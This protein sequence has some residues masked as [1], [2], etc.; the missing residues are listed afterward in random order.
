LFW[1]KKREAKDAKEKLA[2]K[3]PISAAKTMPFGI[4]LDFTKAADVE[5]A[6]GGCEAGRPTSGGYVLAAGQGVRSCASIGVQPGD[7]LRVET[8]LS[9]DADPTNG[10]PLHY[11]VGV[12]VYDGLG[13]ILTWWIHKPPVARSAGIVTVRDDVTMPKG[14]VAARY[15][16]CGDWKGEGAVSNGRINLLSATVRRL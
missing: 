4:S 6:H 10:E 9:V 8:S 5:A 16:A 11:F 3:T 1:G 13:E 2:A 12:L 14:A 15:G 7:K